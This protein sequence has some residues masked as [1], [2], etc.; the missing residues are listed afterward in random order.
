M[1]SPSTALV[2]ESEDAPAP[3]GTSA[4]FLIAICLGV[5]AGLLSPSAGEA[6]SRGIDITLLVMIFLLFFELRLGAI[7][8]AFRNLKFLSIAW[9][10]NFLIV[11]II[12]FAVASLFFSGQM[13]LFAGLMIYF[14]APC[15]DWFLGFT[16]LAK[17]NTELGA[18]LIPINIIS[19]LLLFPF[20]LALLAHATDLL[21]FSALPGMLIQWF[22]LP[23]VAAQLVRFAA[24]RLLPRN[25]HAALTLSLGRCVPFV[26][27]A[28][29]FQIFASQIETISSHLVTVG[30]VVM[31]V[32]LF[33]AATVAAGEILSRLA[34]LGAPE[35]VLL[36]MTMAA[37][38]APLMLALTAVA[39]PDQPLLLVVIVSGML[40]EIPLL[41][42]LNQFQLRRSSER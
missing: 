15:T 18:A 12:G 31:A 20:W 24:G 23:L 29:I 2:Q 25:W 17:G 34:R 28:L 1:T 6:F 37:R 39:I 22:I 40:V 35:Q 14:L 4:M 8:G 19:Q 13:L 42:L 26:L 36:S 27:A 11:P 41:I 21:E 16:R 10:A 30:L 32:C 3:F 38:N 5:L 9:G 33:F 7:F